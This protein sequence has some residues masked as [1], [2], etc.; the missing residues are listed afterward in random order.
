MGMG[1]AVRCVLGPKRGGDAWGGLWY[2]WP[3]TLNEG[4][5]DRLESDQPPPWWGTGPN[6][7][8]YRGEIAKDLDCA[9]TA[10]Q[11]AQLWPAEGCGARLFVFVLAH[12]LGALVERLL[13]GVTGQIVSFVGRFGGG[14]AGLRALVG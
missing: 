12:Q 8:G 14:C 9:D 4:G 5:P 7:G 1:P 11:I 13:R 2:I 10:P 6:D 3:K